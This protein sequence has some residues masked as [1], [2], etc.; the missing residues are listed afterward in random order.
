MKGI[1]DTPHIC[2]RTHCL[3]KAQ[4]FLSGFHNTQPTFPICSIKMCLLPAVQVD[5]I[6]FLFDCFF[7]QADFET[8]GNVVFLYLIYVSVGWYVHASASA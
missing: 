2:R 3:L 7:F 8:G 5:F 4:M 1:S 6:L